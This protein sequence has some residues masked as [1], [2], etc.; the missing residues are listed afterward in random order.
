M[1]RDLHKTINIYLS[2]DLKT[3]N[4]YF[5]EHDPSPLYKRQLSHIFEE[6]IRASVANAKRHSTV[7]YKLKCINNSDEKYADP[8]LYAIKNH[9]NAKRKMRVAEFTRFK[10]RNWIL[11]T[12][13]FILIILCQYFLPLI[14]KK[15]DEAQSVV[16]TSLD[17]LSWVILWRPIDTLLFDW[18]PHL[19]EILILRKLATA[20]MII[21]EAKKQN[22][23]KVEPIVT[24]ITKAMNF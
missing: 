22:L 10:R 1:D 2:V 7:V 14:F 13:S 12:I 6:Y 15:A 18:N 16:I 9:F 11:L 19:K 21:V 4:S 5:N 3:I 23:Q 24:S 20:E 17:V 8:L